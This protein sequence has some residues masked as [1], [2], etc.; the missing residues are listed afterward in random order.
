MHLFLLHP[1]FQCA[2]HQVIRNLFLIYK[3]VQDN[4]DQYANEL[5]RLKSTLLRTVE[6]KKRLEDEVNQVRVFFLS[7]LCTGMFLQI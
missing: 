4:A 1:V 6:E 3:D 7:I 2:L 5:E